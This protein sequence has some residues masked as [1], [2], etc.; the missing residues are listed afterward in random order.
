MSQPKKY[1]LGKNERVKSRKVIQQLFQEGQ[2]ISAFPIRVLFLPS[3][4]HLSLRAG[5]AVSKKFFKK[6]PDRN[7]IKRLMR[8]AYRLQ[9]HEF[10][11]TAFGNISGLDLF[12][13]YTGSELPKYDFIEKKIGKI[14]QSLQQFFT[15]QSTNFNSQKPIE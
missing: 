13:I 9:K 14:F 15:N 11:L 3:N 1:T 6:A 7:R 8:E 10:D 12:F 4:Q 2:S 5:F